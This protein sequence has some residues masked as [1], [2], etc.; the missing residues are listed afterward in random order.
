MLR[1]RGA[2]IMLFVLWGRLPMHMNTQL[3]M[4]DLVWNDLGQT[5]ESSACTH[6]SLPMCR[7]NLRTK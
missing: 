3:D 1:M 7:T 4:L 6:K 2:F 5:R